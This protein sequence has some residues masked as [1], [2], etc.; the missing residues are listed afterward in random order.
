MEEV[1]ISPT[2]WPDSFHMILYDDENWPKP[3]TMQKFEEK[4]NQKNSE[5]FHEVTK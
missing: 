5:N 1:R 4:T 2:M 3:Q